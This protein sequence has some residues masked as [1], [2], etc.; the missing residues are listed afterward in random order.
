MFIIKE[1]LVEKESQEEIKCLRGRRRDGERA[2]SRLR[3]PAL[4]PTP[5]AIHAGPFPPL[6]PG[7]LVCK[8]RG[9]TQSGILS[10]NCT[11]ERLEHVSSPG[12]QG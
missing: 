7:L 12:G 3:I 4:P 2:D 5:R 10:L 8:I 9:V 1:S 6:S 11:L